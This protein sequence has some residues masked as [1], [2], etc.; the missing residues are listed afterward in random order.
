MKFLDKVDNL[1]SYTKKTR[2]RKFEEL[3][4]PKNNNK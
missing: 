3:V 4:I 1:K 2:N